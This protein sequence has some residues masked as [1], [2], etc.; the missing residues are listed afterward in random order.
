MPVLLSGALS[1]VTLAV[2]VAVPP[3]SAG[4]VVAGAVPSASPASPASSA[5]S[6]SSTAEVARVSARASVSCGDVVVVGVDGNGERPRSGAA[7]GPTV[8]RVAAAYGA[9]VGA[10]SVRTVRVPVS[11][12]TLSRLVD[13]H[14]KRKRDAGDAVRRTALRAWMG[15]LTEHVTTA[16]RLVADRGVACPE[17]Q[18]VLVGYA[19]GAAVAHRLLHR[20]SRDGVPARVAG[21][22]LV[23]D[24]DRR[25]RT[26]SRLSGAPAA[27][28]AST[29]LV[30]HRITPPAP[31]VPAATPTF[32][33]STVCTARDLVC[34]PSRTSVRTAFSV[35]RSYATA[36]RGTATALRREAAVLAATTRV[37]PVPAP[38]VQQATGAAGEPLTMQL[39]VDVADSARDGV[40][41]VPT[42]EV[43]G[44]SLSPTGLLSGTP[45]SGGTATL[46]YTVRGTAPTTPPRSGSVTI[47]TAAGSTGLSAAGQGSC[48]TRTDETAWCWGRN[49]Y[50]QVGDGTTARRFTPTQ[51]LGTDWQQVTTGGATTCGIKGTGRL[52]CWGLNNYGQL[53]I[54]RTKPVLRPR[55]VG[56]GT[57]KDVAPAWHHTCGV[58]TDESLWC[59]GQNIR[60][61]LGLG[62]TSRSVDVPRKVGTASWRSV[63]SGGW[64]SCGIRTDGS[65]W[66]WGDNQLGQLGL[67]NDDRQTAPRR[68]GAE[69]DRWIDLSTGYGHT[70]GVR[71][72]GTLQCWGLNDRGQLGDGTQTGRLSPTTVAGTWSDVAVSDGGT[73]ALA[74]SGGV[75]CWGDNRYGQVAAPSAVVVTRPVRRTSP[76]GASMLAAGW[77]HT[78]AARPDE[79]VTCWG[80]NEVG[81]AAS[82]TGTSRTAVTGSYDARPGIE[83]DP[84]VSPAEVV[85]RE[86]GDRPRP[87]ASSQRTAARAATLSARLMTFNVLGT[88][89][90]AP[91]GSRP[92][93]APARI[94][95]EWAGEIVRVRGADLVGTQETN[96]DQ[97]GSLDLA[98]GRQFAFYPGTTMGYGGAT[99]SVMWRKD[100]WTKQW[101]DTI[102]VPFMDERRPM[103]MVRLRHKKTGREVYLVNVHYSPGGQEADRDRGTAITIDA[104][105]KLSKD[106]IPVL[107]TGDFN[108][109]EELYCKVHTQ[110]DLRSPIAPTRPGPACHPP[111]GLRV[112]QIFGSRGRFAGLRIDQGPLVQRTTDHSVSVVSFSVG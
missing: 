103:P 74:G 54:G 95:A 111:R 81:Q 67:G 91:G 98:T 78:C 34:D 59:W 89:H 87:T 45:T 22:V 90:T 9:R 106:G 5:S 96:P 17:E 29:G 23:S 25:Y 109:R 53:G 102:S 12:A 19:Q 94:R 56:T 82:T 101:A 38:A 26:R 28:H 24:P 1:A 85:E 64:H 15:P 18:V 71:A 75:W 46:T 62:T 32:G 97:I 63:V 83:S 73:C 14:D 72:D 80:S 33:V 108:E 36:G 16:H 110:T 35:A 13:G 6:G 68:V 11:T 49:D 47:V 21:A 42:N 58:A 79:V 39:A 57:W 27:P 40:R 69:S 105:K 41:W 100:V 77:L 51:V 4:P 2:L 50:G 76:A 66:C 30:V 8:T 88:R 31:D 20:W 112:D 60:G 86:I 10:R 7:F 43:A 48:Q 93:W 65:A 44:M 61:S 107:L 52:S 92:D 84:E 55:Q 70:C 3:A 37:R 104:I 99:T